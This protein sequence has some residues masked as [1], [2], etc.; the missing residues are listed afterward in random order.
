MENL[1][2]I[3][4]VT[5]VLMTI[6]GILGFTV[7]ILLNVRFFRARNF[8]PVLSANNILNRIIQD[9]KF[10]QRLN[11]PSESSLQHFFGNVNTLL[12]IIDKQ[13]Q[14]LLTVQSH[15][16]EQMRTS[17]TRQRA[18]LDHIV[19]G[20]I[21]IDS[22]GIIQ[23]FN[24]AAESIFGY[25][26]SEVVNRNVKILMPEPYTTEHDGYLSRYHAT[27]EA[28]VIGI[29]REVTGRRKDGSVFPLEL[30]VSKM[31]IDDKPLYSGIVRDITAR[32]QAELA[33]LAAE[34]RQRAVLENIVDGIITID[35]RGS[36]Q[37]F[38]RAAENIFGYTADEVTGKNVKMLMPQ[39]YTDEHDQYLAH[40]HKTGEAHVIGIGREVTGR[41]KDNSVFPLELAVSEMIID[42]KVLYSGIVR[43][44][45]ERKNAEQQIIEARD[46]AEKSTKAKTEFLANMSHEIRT[47]MNAVINL[48]YLAQRDDLPARTLDYLAK[49]ENS[50]KNLLAI[51][52]DILDISKVEAG[53]LELEE[54][55]FN[56][57]R[58]VNGLATIVG[59]RDIENS[60]EVMFHTGHEVPTYMIGDPL[61]LNQILTNL[62]GNALKF[63]EK[64][65][66]LFSVSLEQRFEDHCIL[67][68]SVRDSG[69]GMSDKQLN[70]L[71]QPFGQADGSISRRYGGTGLGLAISQHLVELMQGKIAVKSESGIGST[72][73]FSIPLRINNEIDQDKRYAYP[74]LTNL[75]VLIVDDNATARQITADTLATMG[76]NVDCAASGGEA[77]QL[78]NK[79]NSKTSNTYQ[80]VLLDWKMPGMDGIETLN[81]IRDSDIIQTQPKVILCTAYG[82]ESVR[83]S[84][85][86]ATID[87]YLGKPFSNS[88]L[89]DVIYRCIGYS[90]KNETTPSFNL[91]EFLARE[92]RKISGA[93]IL[94]V[95]DNEINLMIA[96]E[97]LELQG[98]KVKTENSGK[99][100]IQALENERFDL[101]LMDVQMPEMN[102]LETTRRIRETK[103]IDQ[104]PIIA[105][106]AHAME[107][108]RERSL[109]AGMNDHLT[110]P[111]D[112]EEL[113]RTLV[114]W[115]SQNKAAGSPALP[116]K[117]AA[118]TIFNNPIPGIDAVAGLRQVRG[119]QQLYEKLLTK[120]H[121]QYHNASQELDSLINTGAHEDAIRLVHSI[122]GV[123]GSLGA[124]NLHRVSET[125]EQ[126]LRAQDQ[127][128]NEVQ[129]AFTI[130]LTEVMNGLAEKR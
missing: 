16:R 88:T 54:I 20:I 121:E 10:S 24:R 17:D 36:I 92:L 29:G 26:S 93:R 50:G 25:D 109:T 14:E 32:K 4:P 39:P 52:N 5:A 12:H 100:A 115:L 90:T 87:G 101:V 117:Q 53:K 108:D 91:E 94:V 66:I 19:D 64:G 13:K 51:I 67:Q 28:H 110:K 34:T 63:T 43:D 96:T 47:P 129:A 111:I 35:Q 59:Y 89:L 18:V 130:A 105:M 1:S 119:N 126:K 106:T 79:V 40:Y 78:L 27:G 120:M 82:V 33:L 75:K 48:A 114:K 112:P 68:F 31:I 98:F 23:N 76:I 72:F 81:A 103:G 22:K 107:S 116:N 42:G 73:S 56:L 104:P 83:E 95:D 44:I 58:L 57:H 62:I 3:D 99:G 127:Q 6:I 37:T 21:T 49:I 128:A 84:G 122:K 125:L 60:I 30:A 61:R 124:H 77:L 11:V 97:L 7:V 86:S 85:K 46:V 65:E 118:Q 8:N 41:R 102:G 123:A 69:I 38:N 45:T 9:N 74:P 71:F 55:P 70:Q 15:Y 113:Y 80:I 2:N